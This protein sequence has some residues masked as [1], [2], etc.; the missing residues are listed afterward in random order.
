MRGT[1]SDALRWT[2]GRSAIF[3]Y[4]SLDPLFPDA[5]GPPSPNEP[6]GT[7]VPPIRSKR[8]ILSLRRVPPT[9]PLPLLPAESETALGAGDGEREEAEDGATPVLACRAAMRS[10]SVVLIRIRRSASGESNRNVSGADIWRCKPW[11][12]RRRLSKVNARDF[13]NPLLFY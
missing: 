1:L 12:Q 3:P 8:A 2:C 9:T 5:K 7:G 11:G 4:N 6:R 13:S 10:L